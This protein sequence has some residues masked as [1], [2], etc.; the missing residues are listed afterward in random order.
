MR[1]SL[2]DSDVTEGQLK[3]WMR[4]HLVMK[5]ASTN[6]SDAGLENVFAVWNCHAAI[7]QKCVFGAILHLQHRS[8]FPIHWI[9][10]AEF[11]RKISLTEVSL[12]AD[13]ANS[14]VG[15]IDL[16]AELVSEKKI[17]VAVVNIRNLALLLLVVM[18]LIYTN[19]ECEWLP[20][21]DIGIVAALAGAALSGGR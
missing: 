16:E 12:V 21:Y 3:N 6:R 11:E 17:Y 13:G 1:A 15:D 4:P 7:H 18:L 14:A 8:V 2:Q 20:K 5:Q 10:H 9:G 19:M